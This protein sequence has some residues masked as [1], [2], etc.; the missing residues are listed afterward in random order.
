MVHVD[1]FSV[2]IGEYEV[3]VWTEDI[4]AFESCHGADTYVLE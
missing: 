3:T 1:D 4:S 2:E